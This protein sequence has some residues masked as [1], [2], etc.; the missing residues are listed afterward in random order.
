MLNPTWLDT[1]IGLVE[2]GSFTRTAE[3]RFMTQPGVSQHLKKLEDACYCTLVVRLGKG[4]QLTEQGKRVYDYAKSQQ[5]REQD[6]ITSL[7]FDNP[8]EGEC[9]VACS[10][11]IAQRIYPAL[12]AL[13]VKHSKLNIHVEVAPRQTILTGIANNEVSLGVVTNHP[14]SDDFHC[15]YL[16][17]ETLGLILPKKLSTTHQ[18][19]RE[20]GRID[21]LIDEL[22]LIDHPDAM[23]YLKRYIKD[24]G[25]T[26]LKTINPNRIK[27]VG[28]INQLSQILLPVSEGL[29]FTVLPTSTLQFTHLNE[30]LTIHSSNCTVTEPLY[31]VQ[32]QHHVL[33]ARYGEIQKVVQ[34]LLA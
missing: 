2:T 9:V 17:E 6:F 24:C 32:R 14:N 33:P 19:Y 21:K 18:D 8:F 30:Q 34:E 1:F 28:Y 10:G 16:G 26:T 15:T 29:G 11:A 25:D 22:G 5:G 27:H 7:K 31:S 20:K 4:I 23:Y 12:V 13:L 3:Q